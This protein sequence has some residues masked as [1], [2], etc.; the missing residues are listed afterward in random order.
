MRAAQAVVFLADPKSVYITGQTLLVVDSGLPIR[1]VAGHE[2][3]GI[4]PEGRFAG[5]SDYREIR[6]PRQV[7]K[8]DLR[9]PGQRRGYQIVQGLKDLR[10]L[11]REIA[12]GTESNRSGASSSRAT[13]CGRSG[14]WSPLRAQVPGKRM[15]RAGLWMEVSTWKF[16][17]L[18]S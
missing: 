17:S 16:E 15:M 13:R 10:V 12:R 5:R 9:Q 4:Q 3:S 6:H 1:R 18:N 2:G 14:R 11:A 8:L 7:C